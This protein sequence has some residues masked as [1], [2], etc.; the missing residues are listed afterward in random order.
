MLVLAG[1]GDTLVDPRCSSELAAHWGTELRM[2]PTAGHDL[3]L[4]DGAWVAHE[5][6]RW[7]EGGT[8]APRK[9]FL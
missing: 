8:Q 5:V 4:D 9:C 3:P 6:S 2:H 7:L 1:A